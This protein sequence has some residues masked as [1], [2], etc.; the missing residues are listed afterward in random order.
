MS[1]ELLLHNWYDRKVLYNSYFL[2]SL[3]K[4]FLNFTHYKRKIQCQT[5]LVLIYNII[6]A[7]RNS[8]SPV[9]QFLLPI[10]I[11]KGKLLLLSRTL[12]DCWLCFQDM[13]C[14]FDTRLFMLGNGTILNFP[15]TKLLRGFSHTLL[16]TNSLWTS[17]N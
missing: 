1:N 4:Y 10:L 12:L 3:H 15:K 7:K 9:L 2:T 11:L 13:L 6:D 5:E 16:G 17:G 8:S 14:C